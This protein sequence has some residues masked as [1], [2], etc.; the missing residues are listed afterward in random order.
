[1]WSET[2]NFYLGVYEG[3]LR[4]FNPEG[5]LILTPEEEALQAQKR[6]ERLAAQLRAMGVE[7]EI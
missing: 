2:L 5:R 7:P 6:A 1:M 3:Q 4:Y